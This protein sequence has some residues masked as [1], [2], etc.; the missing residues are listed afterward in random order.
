MHLVPKS[1]KG[2]QREKEMKNYEGMGG[3]KKKK[4]LNQVT[5]QLGQDKLMLTDNIM[6]K[7]NVPQL[8]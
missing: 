4:K 5:Q 8:G 1:K 3:G 2:E 7:T 6:C